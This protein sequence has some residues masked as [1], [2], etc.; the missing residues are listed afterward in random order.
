[1]MFNYDDYN[2]S[3]LEGSRAPLYHYTDTWALANI[4]EDDVLKI[5]WYDNPL[6]S[7]SVK[8][9]SLSRDSLLNIDYYRDINCR[10]VL[11]KDLLLKHSYKVIPYDFFIQ[12]NKTNFGKIETQKRL[13]NRV[14]YE[15][16]EI[17]LKDI[18]NVGR[19]IIS[20]DFYELSSYFKIER[21]L[22]KYKDINS[23]IVYNL[24]QNNKVTE[25]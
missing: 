8:I 10:I 12:S 24:I 5:G 16:E 9:I 25:L 1:M 20:I 6:G 23:H 7:D 2:E 14:P 18:E 15:S 11:N 17:L 19:F 4:I 3:Y 21:L 22:L 13:D